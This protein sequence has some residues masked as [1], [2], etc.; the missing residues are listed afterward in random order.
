MKTIAKKIIE[1]LKVKEYLFPFRLAVIV[2]ALLLCPNFLY[3]AET[4]IESGEAKLIMDFNQGLN[5]PDGDSLKVV[6]TGVQADPRALLRDTSG[7]SSYWGGAFWSNYN[8]VFVNTNGIIF[9]ANANIQAAS[10]IASTLNIT[11]NDFLNGRYN[12]FKD[13][14]NAFLINRGNIKFRNGGYAILLSQAVQNLGNIS[15]EAGIG[16]VALAAGEAMTLN[17]DDAGDISVV[18]DQAVKSIVLGENGERITSAVK[19][20]GTIV[21]NGGK[22]ILTAKVLNSVFDY[23]VNNSGIIE[24]KNIVNHNGVI[25]ISAAGAPVINSGTLEAGKVTVNVTGAG[26]INIGKVIADGSADLPNGG[27]VNI[28]ALTILQQGL[29]SAN[30]LEGGDAG[31]V[32]LISVSSTTLDTGSATEAKALGIIGNGGRIVIDSTGGKTLVNKDA[33]IDIS[34]GSII[35]NA[36]SLEVGAFD[37][38]GFFGILNGRAPPWGLPATIKVVYHSPLAT[39]VIIVTDLADYPSTGTPIISGL[40]FLPGQQVTLNIFSPDGTQTTLTVTAD[41][42]GSFT[43]TYTP[44][45]SLQVGN[46]FVTGSDGARSA[47]TAFTDAARTA[48]VSG[49]WS[50]TATWGGSAVPTSADTVV[51]NGGVTVTVDT[52][53]ATCLSLTLGSSDSGTATLSFNNGSVLTVTGSLTIGHSG[54]GKTGSIDMTNGGT[55]KIGGTG[56]PVTNTNAG[57]WTPGTGTVEYNGAAQTVDTSFFNAGPKPY[58]NNLT[59]SGSGAKTLGSPIAANGNLTI[60]SGSTLDVSVSNYGISIAGNWTNNGGTFTPRSGTVTFNGSG[61]QAITSGG[62]SFFNLTINKTGGS[63][64]PAD[65]NLNVTG[66]HT[67][68]AGT[69]NALSYNLTTFNYSQ[70]GGAFLGNGGTTTIGGFFTISGGTFNAYT[71]NATAFSG[72]NGPVNALIIWTYNGT[73]YLIA[74][75]GFTTAGGVS[76]NY[77]AKWDGSTWSSLGSGMSATV[78]ALTTYNG[79]LIAGGNFTT[80]GGVSAN[81]IA[82]WDGSTWSALGSGI[83][84]LSGVYALTTYNGNLIAGGWFNSAGGN[85]A[86]SIAQ[87]NGS[88]WSSLGS[89]L[90]NV[91]YALTTYNGNLI[92]GGYFFNYIV[93]WP[94]IGPVTVAGNLTLSGGTLIAPSSTLTVSGNWTN[95]GGTFNAGSGTVIFNG[96][97]QSDITGNNKFYNLT[98]NTTTDGA[99]TVRFGAGNTQTIA[100]NLVL[101][102]ASGKI[103]TIRSTTGGVQAILSIPSSVTSG[104]NYVDVKDNQIASPNTITPGP[105]SIDSGN[106]TRWIFDITP[107]SGSITINSDAT[108]VNITSVTLN[109]SATDAVGVTG[110]R[111]ANGSDASGATTT[112]VT[113]ATSYSSNVSWTLPTGDGTKTVAVQYCDAAGNWSSNYTDSIILDTTPPT[114]T[115]SRTPI[116]NG[117]GWNNVDV[118]ASYTASDALSRLASPS[119]GSHTFSSEGS[120]QSITFTVSDNAGNTSSVTVNNINIDKTAPTI[121]KASRTAP[122]GDG[123]IW[124]NND[125]TVTFNAADTLGTAN[126]GIDTSASTLSVT[127][128]AEG[129]GQTATGTAYDKAGNHTSLDEVNINIDKTAPT[130]TFGSKS[131]TPTIYDWNNT[132]VSIGFIPG[133]SLSGV[134]TVSTTSPLTFTTEGAGQTKTVT[135]TDKAG[136]SKTFTSPVVNIDKT[137]PTLTWNDLNPPNTAGWN[138]T[139]VSLAYTAA[140]NLSGVAS[141]TPTSPLTF[142]TEGAGQIKTVTVTDR[143][144]NSA[145]F[146]SRVVNIDK[147]APTEGTLGVAPSTLWPPNG[148]SG[149]MVNV[150]I[151]GAA[152]DS[153]SGIAKTEITQVVDEYNKLTTAADLDLGNAVMLDPSRLGTDKDG[154]LYTITITA[155]DKAGNSSDFTR[156]VVV[157]H[158]M[159]TNTISS[160]IAN[161]GLISGSFIIYGPTYDPYLLL[162]R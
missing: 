94:S 34:S 109:L 17:L 56:T 133:D 41:A 142:T 136:N 22:V 64:S 95:N 155:W 42:T 141:G 4:V 31:E 78:R 114:I 131:P 115:A 37:Q 8:V 24:A 46:Y 161:G 158:D 70:T 21:A 55:L 120:G 80:A 121:S 36:G 137:L 10:L 12:F 93:Q 97:S 113:S 147:S 156:Y 118:V 40:G 106:N 35:G 53:S 59:L 33:V 116:A 129:A 18:I 132:N 47:V 69:F 74:G 144:G 73:T 52:A 65:N 102:G 1:A 89:G 148:N 83:T 57:T 126:S 27:I 146:T 108:Y 71:L 44:E 103:L 19:N 138:N 43:L 124:N 75:G 87:W 79:N 26:F 25:E 153:G 159:G 85:S 150:S 151:T 154:R 98:I 100:Y 20:D 127:K 39:P 143:A 112:P 92:A 49:L 145:T 62:S 117:F 86:N 23:A 91:V 30:A 45:T 50:S 28:Q 105:N 162:M 9:G 122:T 84:G 123:T 6:Y 135:V 77:I 15:I 111:V 60:N 134:D 125:V 7:K 76:A 104:V 11:N 139:S 72:F 14:E 152:A 88:T 58:Y 66:T 5:I 67:L 63:V 101:T 130:L 3:A 110:Y 61:S 68:A 38:L 99:K 82:K 2:A 54:I 48:S 107:P 128:T 29:I 32:S 90:D 160:A 51:I 140:D 157:P 149:K 16:S 119:S 96:T 81:C 13:G